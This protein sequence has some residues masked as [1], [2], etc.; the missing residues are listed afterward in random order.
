M[1]SPPLV[2]LIKCPGCGI[3]KAENRFP[4]KPEYNVCD[5][6]L[7]DAQYSRAMQRRADEAERAFAQILDKHDVP[8]LARAPKMDEFL[9]QLMVEFGGLHQFVQEY[10]SQLKKLLIDKPGHPSAVMAMHAIGK[11]I[12]ENNKRSDTN[13]LEKMTLEQ[14]EAEQK[15]EIFKQLAAMAMDRGQ[16]KLLL[17][18]LAPIDDAELLLTTPITTEATS[19]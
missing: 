11:M 10:A 18:L 5:G 6:C 19:G 2:R 8:A 9:A 15:R 7:P 13:E 1:N 3:R 16:Q 12:N 17:R 14:A 4:A